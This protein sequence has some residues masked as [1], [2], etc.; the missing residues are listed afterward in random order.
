MMFGMSEGS[1]EA[2]RIVI[3]ADEER[4]ILDLIKSYVESKG[5][6]AEMMPVQKWGAAAVAVADEVA[7]GR[8]TFGIVLCYSGT[9]VSIAANKVVGVRAAL[10]TDASTARSARK[11]ND[12]NVLALSLRTLSDVLAAEIIDAWLENRYAGT[13]EESLKEIAARESAK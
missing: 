8:A 5:H 4:P 6:T 10:C 12:A 3:G 7:S 9:G 11:W 2:M 13:E 1:A